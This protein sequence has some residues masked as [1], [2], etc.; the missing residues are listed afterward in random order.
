MPYR[1]EEWVDDE[2]RNVGKRIYTV[3]EILADG[4]EE[5]VLETRIP[6]RLRISLK[7]KNAI[8]RKNSG[9]FAPFSERCIR[10][11]DRLP[12]P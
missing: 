9:R 1:V 12:Q 2:S 11:G 8:G 4:T 10:Q 7:A 6:T 5:E 3:Y